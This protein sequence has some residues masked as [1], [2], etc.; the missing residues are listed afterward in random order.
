MHSVEFD[1]T[2]IRGGGTPAGGVRRRGLR[3]PVFG[4]HP[5][6]GGLA[7]LFFLNFLILTTVHFAGKSVRQATFIDSLGAANLPW[8]YL[9]VAVISF[10]VLVVYSRLAARIQL[11]MLILASTLLHVIGLVAFFV[12]FGLGQEWVAV[13]YYIWLGMAFAIAVS[14][15]WTYANQVFDPR[16]AR[17]LFSF[18]GAGGL[19]GSVLGGTMAVN[20]T[21]ALGTRYTLLGAAAVLLAVPLMIV[22]IERQHN[23]MALAPAKDRSVRLEE[24]HGGLRTLRGS[25]LLGLIAMLMLATVTIGQLVQWQ[26]YWYV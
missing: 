8:V 19:L 26:F 4:M 13:A 20:V 18:I 12:L 24:A 5:G 1:R 6:E 7:W 16:Q 3:G 10:P 25:R 23:P 15:F 17:R 2:G 21:R 14:Q 22:L 11:P 9:A